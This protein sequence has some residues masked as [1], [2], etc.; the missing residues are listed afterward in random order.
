MNGS[1]DMGVMSSSP[2]F[3]INIKTT[4]LQR[5][6]LTLV[7]SSTKMRL[8]LYTHT[9]QRKDSIVY[10]Q[11]TYRDIMIVGVHYARGE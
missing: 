10:T 3:P 7:R 5:V 9:Y 8:H 1:F 11:Q 4:S 6:T 2:F